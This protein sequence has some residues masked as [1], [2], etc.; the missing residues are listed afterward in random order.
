MSFL[1]KL[2]VNLFGLSQILKNEFHKGYETRRHESIESAR[3]SSN[4][5][6]EALL[7][8]GSLFIGCPNEWMD[9]VI[10][11]VKYFGPHDVP[12]VEDILTGKIMGC[13][14]RLIP[15]SKE[16]LSVLVRLNPY[17]RYCLITSS[18]CTS[19]AQYIFD[20]PVSLE[21]SNSLTSSEILEAKFKSAGLL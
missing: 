9:F 12:M 15:Y 18:H 21:D 13:P 19:A 3:R 14:M 17:E 8:E 5:E 1:Q 6:K 10:G 20:K 4:L 7:K 2:V 11:P 16:I